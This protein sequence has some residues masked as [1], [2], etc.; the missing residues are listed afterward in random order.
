MSKA[1]EQAVKDTAT[2]LRAA[3]VE[4]NSDGQYDFADVVFYDPAMSTQEKIE[5]LELCD[6]PNERIAEQLAELKGWT[7]Q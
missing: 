5:M 4:P 7:T 3:G 2:A 1:I 6:E